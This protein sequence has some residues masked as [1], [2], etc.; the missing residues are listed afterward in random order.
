[1]G[2]APVEHIKSLLQRTTRGP[3]NLHNNTSD[4]LPPDYIADFYVLL[5]RMMVQ[6]IY[7]ILIKAHISDTLISIQKSSDWS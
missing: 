1:M 2:L 3:R 5:G 6:V 4:A 7:G